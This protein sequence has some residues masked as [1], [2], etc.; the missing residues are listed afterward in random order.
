[1]KIFYYWNR[2]RKRS[3]FPQTFPKV[4][5]FRHLTILFIFA[6]HHNLIAMYVTIV[7]IANA[8]GLS[9]STVSRALSGDSKNVS[10]ETEKMVLEAA[11]RMGYVRNEL[12][13]NL[14]K[15][16]TMTVGVLVP[17]LSTDFY[18]NFIAQIQPELQNLGYRIIVA[19]SNEDERRERSNIGLL[20]DFILF[21]CG[22]Y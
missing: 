19:L 15:S 4:L 20:S 7:D 6:S 18:N 10:R 9:T 2:S 22:H 16:R 3:Q 1:M 21:A 12:A 5:L 14:R 13:V 11:E 17:E 8:L